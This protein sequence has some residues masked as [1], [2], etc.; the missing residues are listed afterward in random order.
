[1]E[2]RIILYPMVVCNDLKKNKGTKHKVF[3]CLSNKG[4]GTR[5]RGYREE[6]VQIRSARTVFSLTGLGL[7]SR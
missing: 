3:P 2:V 5:E 7:L 1:M 4:Q 6:S